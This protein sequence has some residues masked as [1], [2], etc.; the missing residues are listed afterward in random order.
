MLPLRIGAAYQVI[1]GLT[2]VDE[3]LKIVPPVYE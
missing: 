1:S 3:V 2:T